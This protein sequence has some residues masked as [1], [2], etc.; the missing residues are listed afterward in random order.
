MEVEKVK[1]LPLDSRFAG[2]KT[3]HSHIS[4]YFKPKGTARRGKKGCVGVPCLPNV[5]NKT[6][7]PD[8]DLSRDHSR[9]TWDAPQYV[10]PRSCRVVFRAPCPPPRALPT[11]TKPPLLPLRLWSS[12]RRQPSHESW[13]SFLLSQWLTM[14]HVVSCLELTA[15]PAFCKA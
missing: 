2:F 7:H 9:P 10:S 5:G 14:S 12:S 15:F 13:G 11:R 8:S 6:R 3:L 4:P 1:H